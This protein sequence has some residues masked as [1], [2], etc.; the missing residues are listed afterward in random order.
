MNCY[1][2]LEASARSTTGIMPM[3]SII[4]QSCALATLSVIFACS[5][6]GTDPIP[7]SN[8]GSTHRGG[9]S[10][11]GGS[12]VNHAGT[13][14][15]VSAGAGG[16]SAGSSATGGSSFGGSPIGQTGGMAHG[17]SGSGGGGRFG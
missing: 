13:P 2:L 11:A 14:G 7:S 1:S 8:G 6:E 4:M 9:A 12:L 5:A 3:R 17:G 16:T 10:S 15:G